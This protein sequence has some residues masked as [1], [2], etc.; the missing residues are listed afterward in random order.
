MPIE[1]VY[2]QGYQTWVARNLRSQG[3][4]TDLINEEAIQ[5]PTFEFRMDGVQETP[6]R[7][8]P[9]RRALPP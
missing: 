9:I 8:K 7:L 5:I 3:T 4:W 6:E 1:T 2:P